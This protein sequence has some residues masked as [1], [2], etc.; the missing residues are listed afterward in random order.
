M[1]KTAPR[2]IDLVRPLE[3]DDKKIQQLNLRKP[4]SGELRGTSLAQLLTM[5]VD[6]VAEV[7]ER[8]SDPMV[9]AHEYMKMD[10][11]D[12]TNIAL[13]VTGFLTGKSVG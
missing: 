3:R 13:E 12:I 1:N 10:P 8:I 6:S 11:V 5:D 9:P 2:T 4:D 7:V